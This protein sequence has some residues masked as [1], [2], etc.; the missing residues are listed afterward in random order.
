MTRSLWSNELAAA[1]SVALHA[2]G[3]LGEPEDVAA[4]I[5]WLLDPANHWV[6]GQ[7]F[8]VDGGLANVRARAKR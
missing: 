6:T 1:G 8:G 5:A 2:L 7:L 3:R 4:L